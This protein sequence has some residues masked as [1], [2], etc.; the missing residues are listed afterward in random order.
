MRFAHAAVAAFLIGGAAGWYWP[1]QAQPA[2]PGP[3]QQTQTV[4][5]RM[6]MDTPVPIGSAQAVCTGV[7]RRQRRR[8]G[9][10]SGLQFEQARMVWGDAGLRLQAARLWAG[11]L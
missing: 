4:P 3:G 6:P 11:L 10:R 8:A 5:Q 9:F 2:Q 1:A 7:D